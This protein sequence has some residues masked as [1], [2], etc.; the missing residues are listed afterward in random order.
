M[1]V[2]KAI[3]G[4]GLKITPDVQVT[5]STGSALDGGLMQVIL[6]RMVQDQAEKKTDKIA[7]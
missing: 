3:A 7:S 2:M 6:S 5:G 1:E 4:A